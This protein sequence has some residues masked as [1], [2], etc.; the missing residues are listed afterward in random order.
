M[1]EPIL[2]AA[3][4]TDLFKPKGEMSL[5][6]LTIQSVVG[7]IGQPA[8]ETVYPPIVTE[9]GS[10]MN[11][12]HSHEVTMSADAMP[13]AKAFWSATLYG[14]ENGFFLP[15]EHF[16][17]RVGENAEFKLDSEDGIRIVISPER[18]EGVPQENWPPTS[19]GDY[20]I[21]I[22]MRPYSPNLEL[23]SNWSPPI[24]RKLD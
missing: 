23:F 22:I 21:Y 11:A 18:P 16:K 4:M 1:S 17:H 24:A 7:P 19:R 15:N 12:M 14:C 8:T 3:N 2:I 9:D 5:E 13:P 20:G 6:L 10:P